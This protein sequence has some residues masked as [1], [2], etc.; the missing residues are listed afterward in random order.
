MNV[1]AVLRTRKCA[2]SNHLQMHLV[3]EV[4]SVSNKDFL[5][6]I[7]LP[8]SLSSGGSYAMTNPRCRGVQIVSLLLFSPRALRADVMASVPH[9]NQSQA[10]QKT[11]QTISSSQ[12]NSHGRV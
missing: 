10:A 5:S 7:S 8:S 12:Q 11:L 1:C 3:V 6:A 4:T 9:T 2:R